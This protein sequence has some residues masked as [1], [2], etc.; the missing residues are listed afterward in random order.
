MGQVMLEIF[1]MDKDMEKDYGNLLNNQ[2]LKFM[3]AS[4]KMIKK[5]GQGYINGQMG[6]IIKEL[7][8]KIKNM[9]LVKQNIKMEN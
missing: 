8:R 3:M 1:K 6:L 9:E 2:M 7:L 5:A 4:I